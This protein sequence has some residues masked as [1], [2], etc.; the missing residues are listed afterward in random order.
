M[1]ATA[2]ERALSEVVGFVM[3]LGVIVVGL[4]IYQV[5]VVPAEGR[6]DEIVHMDVINARFTDYKISL[7]SLWLNNWTGST[8]STSFDLGTGGGN[9]LNPGWSLNLFSPIYSTGKV[10]VGQRDEMISID[11]NGPGGSYSANFTMGELEYLSGNNYWIQQSYRYQ[12]G[13]VFLTQENEN[14]STIRILPSFSVYNIS[15]SGGS[16][17][18]KVKLTLI[19]IQG[20]Q[21]ITGGGPVRVDTRL[22]EGIERRAYTKQYNVTITVNASDELTARTWERVFYQTAMNGNI[23][24]TW[25]TIDRTGSNTTFDI[26]GKISEGVDFDITR[27]SYLVSIQSLAR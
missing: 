25:Y 13:G 18:A 12:M 19:Q 24:A 23:P 7:D 11:S 17:T 15:R 20:D 21:V 2:S 9:T 27:A 3:I 14:G 4:S 5:Y 16:T 10:Q 26:W 8:L 1:D 22:R 6:E